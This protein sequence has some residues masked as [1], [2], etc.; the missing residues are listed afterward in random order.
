MVAVNDGHMA[1]STMQNCVSQSVLPRSIGIERN[2]SI[3]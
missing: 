1:S 2:G 3:L